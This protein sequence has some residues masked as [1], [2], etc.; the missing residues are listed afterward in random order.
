MYSRCCLL[1]LSQTLGVRHIPVGDLSC[2]SEEC[3]SSVFS[4]LGREWPQTS[5]NEDRREPRALSLPSI[6]LKGRTRRT[7]SD[8]QPFSEPRLGLLAEN[9]YRTSLEKRLI[10]CRAT[11]HHTPPAPSEKTRAPTVTA[12]ARGAEEGEHDASNDLLYDPGSRSRWYV[13]NS[14]S[15]PCA[16]SAAQSRRRDAQG[17]SGLTARPAPLRLIWG[18]GMRFRF[19]SLRRAAARR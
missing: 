17:A 1:A 3:R 10:F 2:P 14:I 4:P 18:A 8:G 15:R 19:P 12:A 7:F 5:R 6:I 13:D 11:S 9:E 16:T